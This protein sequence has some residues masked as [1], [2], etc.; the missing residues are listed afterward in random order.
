LLAR[1]S[2]AAGPN[3]SCKADERATMARFRCVCALS[4]RAQMQYRTSFLQLAMGHFLV[5]CFKVV[6]V[7]VLLKRFGNLVPWTLP[8]VAFFHG[9][10]VAFIQ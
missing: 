9:V 6:G 10:N 2:R 5:T 8:Q 3:W 7:W 4:V 1:S